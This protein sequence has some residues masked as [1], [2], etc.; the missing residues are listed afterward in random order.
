MKDKNRLYGIVGTLLFH[1]VVL[2]LLLCFGFSRIVPEEQGGIWVQAGN[3]TEAQDFFRAEQ[4]PAPVVTPPETTPVTRPDSRE[5]MI[6]Q[7]E[8]ETVDLDRTAQKE[9]EK[10]Q[11]EIRR[12]EEEQK[13]KEAEERK[14]REEQAARAADLA[15]GAFGNRSENG[16]SGNRESGEGNEG[17]LSGNAPEGAAEGTGGEGTYDL[18]GRSVGREGLPKPAYQ[19]QEEGRIVIN[20]V[21]NA[22]GQVI[23]AEIG[24]GTTIDNPQLR[25]SAIQ[26]ARKAVFNAIDEKNNQAGII[27]YRYRLK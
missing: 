6:V 16:S 26:A 24:R 20:I 5:D 9:E 14:R 12:K 4:P 7:D 27:T 3:I 21:V 11:E 1:A 22:S 2:I 23:S 17:S 8:E 10:R 19:V 25:R 15:A 13:R 18:D